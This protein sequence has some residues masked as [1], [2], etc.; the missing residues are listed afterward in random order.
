MFLAWIPEKDTDKNGLRRCAKLKSWVICNCCYWGKA[1]SHPRLRTITID[2]D[3]IID[4]LSI[5]LNSTQ[6]SEE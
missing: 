6:L 3:L 2:N 4:Q 5:Q 1:N